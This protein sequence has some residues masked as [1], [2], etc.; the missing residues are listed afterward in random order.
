MTT[1]EYCKYSFSDLYEAAYG[2]SELNYY[3]KELYKLPREK[4]NDWVVQ[5]AQTA[6]WYT[7]RICGKDGQYYIAFS[8]KKIRV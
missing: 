3:L 4:I 7:K 2:K 1:H 8:P 5:T 6:K